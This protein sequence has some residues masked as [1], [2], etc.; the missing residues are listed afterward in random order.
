MSFSTL[1]SKVDR[2][3]ESEYF[4][5]VGVSGSDPSAAANANFDKF[6][7][8]GF[9]A[10]T[11]NPRLQTFHV[12]TCYPTV[13]DLPHPVASVLVFTAP[14]VTF[15]VVAQCIKAGVKNI[16]IHHGAGPG[17]KSPEATE[18]LKKHAEVNFIDGACPMMFI[19]NSDWFHRGYK[20]ILKWT[21]GLPA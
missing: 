15:D 21:G 13:E 19:R 6:M 9:H 4:A 7:S 2:F 10:I 8:E 12:H 14:K 18:L 16:W 11:I 1:K 5:I 3:F 20:N 17:S